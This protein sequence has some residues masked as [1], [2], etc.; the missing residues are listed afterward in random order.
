MINKFI[1]VILIALMVLIIIVIVAATIMYSCK[2]NNEIFFRNIERENLDKYDKK[3][4]GHGYAFVKRI[5]DILVGIVGSIV[6]IVIF[7]FVAPFILIE[8]GGPIFIKRNFIGYGKRKCTYYTFRIMKKECNG[9]RK[10]L[11]IGKFL[12]KTSLDFMPIYFSVLIGKMTLVGLYRRRLEECLTEE[13][14]EIYLYEKP[15]LANMYIIFKEN[16][17]E[18]GEDLKL[19]SDKYFLCNRCIRLDIQIML[20]CIRTAVRN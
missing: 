15:G 10:Y 20:W 19:Y 11:K 12:Y 2:K 13:E 6:A 17:K 3:R 9:E 18:S 1:D 5:N 16:W 4:K 14:K 8:D 7:I